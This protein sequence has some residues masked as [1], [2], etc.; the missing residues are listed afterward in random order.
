MDGAWVLV[1]VER[2]RDRK[3]SVET[4]SDRS[5]ATLSDVIIRHVLH[6]TV[7]HT[8]S[9]KG[10]DCLEDMGFI[11]R[12]VNHSRFFCDPTTSVHTNTEE[13]TNYSVKTFIPP[14]NRNSDSIDDHL[15]S[16]IW[17]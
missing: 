5:A 12:T 2:I 10:Y 15:S 3:I 1:G 17:F 14:R 4:V 16:F 7:I 6:S 13:G 11:R 8:D 9:W